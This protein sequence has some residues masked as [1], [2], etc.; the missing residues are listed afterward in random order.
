MPTE[1]LDREPVASPARTSRFHLVRPHHLSQGFRALHNRNYRLFWT[2]QLI[3]VTGTWMQTTAQAWLVLK[4]TNSP[5]SLGLVTTLQFLP[6]T[7]LALYGGVLADRLW[8]RRA[9]LFTQLILTIQAFIF[10][11]LVAA[12]V[13]QLW[14]I[15][16]LAVIQGMANAVDTPVRQAFVVEMVG[17]EELTNAVALNSMEFNAARI[18]GPTLAG[19][20]IDRIGIAPTLILNAISYIPVLIALLVMRQSELHVVPPSTRG[21]ATQ[22]L[23]EGLSYAWRSPTVLTVLIVVAAIGTFGYN[24][25]I[26]LPL[27]ARF[28][29]HTNA[30]GFGALASF[31]G[32]GSLVG[33][34][35][36]AYFTNVKVQRLLIASGAFSIIFGALAITRV[37]ALSAALLVAL[38]FAGIIFAITANTLLQ[39]ESPDALRGRIM[40]VYVLLFMGSTPVGGFVIGTLSDV[41]GVPVALFICAALCAAGV[42]VA[43]F[44]FRASRKSHPVTPDYGPGKIVRGA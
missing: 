11:I 24:F 6:V 30:S 33:A 8:K 16:I 23:L 35:V 17:R 19:V 29:L 36:A 20:I 31:L 40:S 5:F 44:H 4:I 9:L 28:V 39:L 41:L 37:F 22:R 1:I 25:S 10:G 21:S 14:Q 15:Y 38:G 18:L 12:G 42:T 7:I 13:I 3:S 32:F 27:L 2:S 34:I 43:V 26:V